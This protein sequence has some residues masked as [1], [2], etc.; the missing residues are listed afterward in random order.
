MVSATELS[1]LFKIPDLIEHYCEHHALN[2]EMSPIAFLKMHYDHPAKD[3]DY[4]KDRKLPFIIH[5]ALHALVF[6]LQQGYK[7]EIRTNDFAPIK[8]E[9]IPSSDTGFNYSVFLNS[10]W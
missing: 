6:T 1:Q 8:N 2:R 5:S 4:K 3:R 10:V 7:F 9:K